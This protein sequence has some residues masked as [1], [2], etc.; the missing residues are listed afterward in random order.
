MPSRARGDTETMHRLLGVAQPPGFQF[1]FFF[2]PFETRSK[3][4]AQVGLELTI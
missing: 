4:V 3:T 2:K 1:Y